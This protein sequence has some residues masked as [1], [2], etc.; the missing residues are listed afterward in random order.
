MDTRQKWMAAIVL[1]S[2]FR[3]GHQALAEP[4]PVDAFAS[5]PAMRSVALSPSGTQV[6]FIMAMGDVDAAVVLERN[7]PKAKHVILKSEPGKYSI[8]RCNWANESRLLCSVGLVASYA[9]KEYRASRLIAVNADGS[10]VMLLF[11]E[12]RHHARDSVCVKLSSC[13]LYATQYQDRVIDWGRSDPGHVLIELDENNDR[14]PSVFSLDVNS[15]LI[16]PHTPGHEPIREFATDG[17][18]NVRLA[19]GWKDTHYDYF[20]RLANDREWQHLARVELFSARDN[21]LKPVDVSPGSDDALGIGNY[22]GRL[23]LWQI[24]LADKAEPHVLFSHAIV[25]INEMPIRAGD[26]RM[27]GVRYDLDLP[28]AFYTDEK[29]RSHIED[30]YSALPATFNFVSDASRDKKVMLV[31]SYSDVT[32]RSYAIFDSNTRQLQRLGNEYPQLKPEALAHERPITYKGSDGTEISGYLTVPPGRRADHL[33]LIVLPHDGPIARDYW[34]F[35]ILVQFLATRGYAVLQT[36]FRGSSGYGSNWL[37]AAHQDWGG[38][39]YSDITEA[40]RWAVRE[41]IADP[42]R[43]AIV[44]WGF[45][46]YA[47]LL[48]AAREKGLY[49]CAVSIAGI[50]DLPLMLREAVGHD[51]YGVLQRELGANSD[52]LR[53][54]SPVRHVDEIRIPLLL[55]HGTHDFEV[56]PDQFRKME[57]ALKSAHKPYKAV[58]IE[59]ASHELERKSDRMILLNELESFLRQ[60][61]R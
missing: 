33:P 4:P 29:L 27:L 31:T 50:S 38:L 9:G 61:V 5:M 53:E 40:A 37:Y 11:S 2:A 39:T 12:G 14:I 21:S 22:E 34:G 30:I 36:N 47:A 13:G 19:Y 59:D 46:G 44:G 24:D 1:L 49:R 28:F 17:A 56:K 60:N 20:A 45:G 51:F 10:D 26:L 23:A 55:I 7:N 52:K 15:G 54:D 43:I 57:R 58:L 32:P 8:N 41:G 3:S 25:D 6:T 18:G 16:K 42:A 48:S 35:D